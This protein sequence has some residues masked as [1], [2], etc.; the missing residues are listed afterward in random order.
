MTLLR[1][2]L[3]TKLEKFDEKL[4]LILATRVAK[5]LAPLL[6]TTAATPCPPRVVANMASPSGSNTGTVAS[7]TDTDELNNVIVYLTGSFVII[8]SAHIVT[9]QHC[10]H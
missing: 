2:W 8:G 4:K 7:S 10:Y 9:H 3:N 6:P 1:V 5:T